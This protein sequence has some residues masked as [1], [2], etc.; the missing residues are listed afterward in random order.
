MSVKVKKEAGFKEA[1]SLPSERDRPA[2]ETCTPVDKSLVVAVESNTRR[3]T[4][5]LPRPSSESPWAA[6]LERPQQLLPGAPP[7]SQGNPST[8]DLS[9]GT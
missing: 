3:P 5:F 1:P 9:S 7:S 8:G 2:E 4:L 6:P